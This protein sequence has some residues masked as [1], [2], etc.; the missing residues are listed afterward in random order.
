V[1]VDTGVQIPMRDGVGLAAS[2]WRPHDNNPVP[3]LLMRTPYGKDSADLL[4]NP[5]LPDVLALVE[6]GYSVVVQDVRGT[7][8][9]EGEFIPHAGDA[10]DGL[11]T[12]D[13]LTEQPWCDGRIGTWGGSYMGIAQW[14]A[15]VHGP[16]ALK[17]MAPVMAS[18]D[19]YR[20]PWHSPGGTL[21]LE[22]FL[23][24]AVRV[25]ALNLSRSDDEERRR[26][27]AELVGQ[28]ADTPA[29]LSQAPVAGHPV[30][31]QRFPWFLTGLDEPAGGSY[32]QQLAALERPGDI[33]VPA[34]N[35]GGWYDP[36]VS[37]TIRAYTT[38][39]EHGG[40]E[41][42]RTG[43][44]LV[45]GPWSH[46]DGMDLGRFPDRSFGAA[47]SIKEFDV[48]EAHIRF[49]DRWVRGR[50]DGTE[51]A[52][53]QIFVMGIDEW[54]EEEAWPL[55]DTLYTDYHLSSS[56][57]ANTAAGD[58]LLST[59]P[60]ER[61]G[62]DVYTYD[63]R[64]PVPTLGGTTLA[65]APDAFPGPADQS[66]VEARDDV[67]CY[68]TPELEMPIEVTG[69]VT[70]VLSVSSSAVDTD[71][72]GKLVDVHPDGGAIILC[73]GIQR[74]R[75]RESLSE[76]ELMNPGEVYEVA[77]DLAA[78]SN[79]FLPGHRIRLEVSSSNFP[80]YDRNT[81]TGGDDPHV[82][83]QDMGAA[84]NHV[85]HGPAHPSRL[86]LPVISR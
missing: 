79:V 29:L 76:P 22:T 73:E 39:R 57:G 85:H 51:D 32:W 15:A 54:R 59:T 34:L 52:P 40:S 9:S 17:A 11:D 75:Y 46:P 62:E 65:T 60:P 30:L 70:L 63:P 56:G 86:V 23:T 78:T 71:F 50:H 83:E 84:V 38:M 20:A 44:R 55:V 35:I 74:A 69:H 45:M 72:S 26:E 49:F 14:Q 1:A 3:A 6:A 28:M 8:S 25:C 41:E 24:W 58:G 10:E 13:W 53:V 12:L 36:F 21:S 4:G 80:R 82:A 61:N 64:Q 48:T 43:Q 77:I 16:D 7:G 37:E 67:L 31:R 81:N 68:T 66:P 27:A 42:A 5:K 19:P 47:S 18:A 2:T 33:M